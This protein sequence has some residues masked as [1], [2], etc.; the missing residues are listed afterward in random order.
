[1]AVDEEAACNGNNKVY[2]YYM[3]LLSGRLMCIFVRIDVCED[4]VYTP[5][6]KVLNGRA[7]NTIQGVLLQVFHI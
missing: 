5:R 3:V 7:S 4:S 2:C 1:M 6:L